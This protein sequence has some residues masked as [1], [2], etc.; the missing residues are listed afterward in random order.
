MLGELEQIHKDGLNL[1]QPTDMTGTLKGKNM[2]VQEY[3]LNYLL[4]D[5]KKH[6]AMLEALAGI[7][8]GMYPYG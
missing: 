3:L 4:E 8:R 5:E 6:A 2:I 7:K 1:I